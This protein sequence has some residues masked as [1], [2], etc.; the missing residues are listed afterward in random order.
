MRRLSRRIRLHFSD[1][2]SFASLVINLISAIIKC[3]HI[4]F[5][6][7]TWK[8]ITGIGTGL[9]CGAQLANLYLADLDTLL[10][11]HTQFYG[12]YLD[13]ICFVTNPENNVLNIANEFHRTIKLDVTSQG[14][15]NVAFLDVELSLCS[16]NSI[17]YELYR[18]PANTG[19]SLGEN[20]SNNFPGSTFEI[21]RFPILEIFFLLNMFEKM[22]VRYRGIQ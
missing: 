16:D 1:R 22:L 18:K 15:S 19:P 14:R 9:A 12:R 13:D 20:E 11:P 21:F 10:A 3:Q 4:V 17:F 7:F 2:P 8:V 6:Q 5:G